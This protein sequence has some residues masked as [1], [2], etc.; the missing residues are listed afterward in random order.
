[1]FPPECLGRHS[2]EAAKEFREIRR[3]GEA[4]LLADGG[5]RCCGVYQKALCFEHNAPVYF[6]FARVP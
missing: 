6:F 4:E 1:M 2:R 3:F 5:G